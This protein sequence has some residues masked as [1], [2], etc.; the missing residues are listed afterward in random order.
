M[1]DELERLQRTKNL[2]ISVGYM[3]RYAPVILKAKELLEKKPPAVLLARYNCAYSEIKKQPWWDT[4]S[5]GG[6]VSEQGTHF[7]DLMRFFGGDIDQDSISA[8][9]IGP[10]YPLIDLPAGIETGIP[11]DRRNNRAT[12][13]NF[14]FP[15]TGAIGS[16]THTMLL[17]GESYETELELI[18]DGMRLVIQN[19]YDPENAKLLVRRGRH[20][21]DN[22]NDTV[23]LQFDRKSDMYY[24]ELHAFLHGIISGDHSRIQSSIRDALQTYLTTTT[25][26]Q[27]SKLAPQTSSFDDV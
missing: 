1:A 11:L 21:V 3:L 10:S 12:T 18:T 2:C 20:Q 22:F 25:I 8:V 24:E 9:A 7:I 15:W 26:T 23:S 14:I 6:P 19:P 4:A 16:F 5:S 13:A 27:R 17:H